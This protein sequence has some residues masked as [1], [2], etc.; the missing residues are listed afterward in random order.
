MNH[1]NSVLPQIFHRLLPSRK[2]KA[3]IRVL[4][5]RKRSKAPTTTVL[6]AFILV[7]IISFCCLFTSIVHSTM[8]QTTEILAADLVQDI[9]KGLQPVTRDSSIFLSFNPINVTFAIDT[10]I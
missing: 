8:T 3:Y 2:G 7:T 6:A 10:Q 4:N 5:T 9:W 1:N